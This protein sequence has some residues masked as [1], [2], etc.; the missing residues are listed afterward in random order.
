LVWRFG[1]DVVADW[2]LGGWAKLLMVAG[3][4]CA[5]C[6]TLTVDPLR[7]STAPLADLSRNAGEV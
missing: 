3:I 5:V 7:G 6:T 2:L 1:R 4:C